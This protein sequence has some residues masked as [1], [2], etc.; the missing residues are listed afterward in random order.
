MAHPAYVAI[1][2]GGSHCLA[3]IYDNQGQ[4]LSEGNGGP[5]SLRFGVDRIWESIEVATAEAADAI[6]LERS[7]WTGLEA[8][9]GL[10]GL[11]G[12][13]DG[14]LVASHPHP[15]GRLAVATD[16][17]TAALG[18]FMGEEGAVLILGTGSCGMAFTPGEGFHSVGGWGFPASDAGSGAR[19]GLSALR[20]S[21]L[22][23]ERLEPASRLAD[24]IMAYFDGQ[25]G[26]LMKWQYTAEPRDYAAFAPLVFRHSDEGDHLATRLVNELLD[27]AEMLARG[28]LAKGVDRIAMG[29][30]IGHRIEP[31]MKQRLGNRLKDAAG[32]AL[33]GALL[34]ARE[35]ERFAPWPTDDPAD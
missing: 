22:V 17:H 6:G 15:F 34:M 18:A 14:E 1:D 33:D 30:S 21:L 24:E 13:E 9:L 2:G 11:V 20:E 4:L 12:A 5:A 23:H 29:G 10:A 28:L 26:N 25:P 31:F 35:P 7:G 3:R 8:A 32:D 19:L 16:A 27:G